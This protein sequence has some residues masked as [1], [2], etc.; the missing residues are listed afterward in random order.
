ME[1][2]RKH[3]PTWLFKAA[4]RLDKQ[5]DEIVKA[6]SDINAFNAGK[7]RDKALELVAAWLPEVEKFSKEIGRQQAYIDSLKEQIGQEADYAGR[8]RDE[9]YAEE[10]KVQKANQKIFELQ[11]TNEQMGRLLKKIPPEV[12]EELQKNNKNRVKER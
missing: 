6:L 1:T 3:I 12:L 4:T 8:M 9:K 10:L 7:K 5:Y 11:K 2:K